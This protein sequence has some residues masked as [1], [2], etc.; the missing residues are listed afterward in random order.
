MN[1]SA[2]LCILRAYFFIFLNPENGLFQTPPPTKSGKFPIFFFFFEPFPNNVRRKKYFCRIFCKNSPSMLRILYK[3]IKIHV[4][5]NSIRF[6]ILHHICHNFSKIN[7]RFTC[8]NLLRTLHRPSI[9]YTILIKVTIKCYS[10][11]I[12]YATHSDLHLCTKYGKI[13]AFFWSFRS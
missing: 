5:R 9:N 7:S 3:F 8:Y 1:I 13:D 11:F 6:D 12:L 4:H 2:F 10:I